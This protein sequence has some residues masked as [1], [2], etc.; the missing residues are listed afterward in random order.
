MEA[1]QHS[2]SVEYEDKCVYTPH[3]FPLIPFYFLH[4]G[5]KP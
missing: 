2:A 3:A 4:W 5:R 1:H